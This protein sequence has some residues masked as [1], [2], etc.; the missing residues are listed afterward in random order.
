MPS[1][2][3]HWNAIHYIRSSIISGNHGNTFLST[4]LHTKQ[5]SVNIN[6]QINFWEETQTKMSAIYPSLE[7]IKQYK[8]VNKRRAQLLH[9]AVEAFLHLES[10]L[11]KVNITIELQFSIHK[12]SVSDPQIWVWARY[13]KQSRSTWGSSIWAGSFWSRLFANLICFLCFKSQC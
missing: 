13:D 7:L 9:K 3:R 6:V 4:L 11:D 10:Q 5:Q 8:R 12:F 1:Y 2:L